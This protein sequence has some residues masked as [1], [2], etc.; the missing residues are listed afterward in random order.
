M[1]YLVQKI[2]T[3]D[4]TKATD[5]LNNAASDGY[6]LKFAVIADA[7]IVA[8]FEKESPLRDAVKKERKPAEKKKRGRPPKKKEG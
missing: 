6:V 1:K 7:R 3:Q 2:P 5:A 8:I 4:T